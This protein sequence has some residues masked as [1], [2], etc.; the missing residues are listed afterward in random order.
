VVAVA[1]GVAVAAATQT[2]LVQAP[3]QH[4]LLDVQTAPPIPQVHTFSVGWQYP[5]QHWRS[6]SHRTFWPRHMQMPSTM[7]VLLSPPALLPSQS[8]RVCSPLAAPRPLRVSA[9]DRRQRFGAAGSRARRARLL[10]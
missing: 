3:S 10:N 4:W 5:L 1:V 9:G 7:I 6:A 2:L 8:W